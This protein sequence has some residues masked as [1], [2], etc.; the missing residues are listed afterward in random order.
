MT[1]ATR[2]RLMPIFD[3]VPEAS[4]CTFGWWAHHGAGVSIR[5]PELNRAGC[6]RR[7]VCQSAHLTAEGC[8]NRHT[9]RV[10]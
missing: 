9:A 10:R 1:C 5:T 7:N 4:L 8:V 3:G 2:T 6:I